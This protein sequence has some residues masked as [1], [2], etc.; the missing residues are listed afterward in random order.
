MTLF[1]Y[2]ALA[3]SS[4]IVKGLKQKSCILLY[5]M[6]SATPYFFFGASETFIYY[7]GSAAADF[8]CMIILSLVNSIWL[9]RR[10]IVLSFYSII[11]NSVGYMLEF[12]TEY[13]VINQI[14][15]LL[16]NSCMILIYLCAAFYAISGGHDIDDGKRDDS[17]VY[18]FLADSAT[19]IQNILFGQASRK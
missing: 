19:L 17:R 12:S 18:N 4:F 1:C 3:S 16:Y 15:T 7:T 8:I 2:I 13:G 11:I 10:L 6:I 5:L 14:T 9:A